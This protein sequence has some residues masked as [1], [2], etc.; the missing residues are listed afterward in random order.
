MK[1]VSIILPV[2]NGEEYLNNLIPKIRNQQLDMEIEIIAAVSKSKDNSLLVA[3]NLCDITYSVG[4]FNHAKTRHEAV[5]KSS[6]EYLVFI[7]QDITPFNEYWLHN[8]ITPLLEGK[9]IVATY[10]RQIAYN[11]SSYTEELVRKFNYPNYDR[12]CN[13]NTKVKWGRKNIFYSDASSATTRAV[14]L[15]LGG[16]DFEI[17]TNED[18]IFALNV[19]ES[20]KSI[21]YNSNSKIYHSHD[22]RIREVFERY[23]LIGSFEQKYKDQLKDYSSLG[24]GKKLLFYLTTAL[25]KKF[26]IKELFLL[27]I[28]M[29]TRYI[30]YKIGY[31]KAIQRNYK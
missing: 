19:I 5:L 30:G 17:E 27:G 24:E 31:K 1:K 10:S 20:G 3:D 6:G 12:V 26:K 13:K 2:Y 11:E 21:L 29:P 16:Y 9:E 14:F 22:F 4:N 7:T 25:I 18:V 15:N 28:D 8:L 23:K